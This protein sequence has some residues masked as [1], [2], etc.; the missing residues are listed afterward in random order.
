VDWLVTTFAGRKTL[1]GDDFFLMQ[2]AVDEGQLTRHAVLAR[3]QEMNQD[4][5]KYLSPIPGISRNYY[6][7]MGAMFRVLSALADRQDTEFVAP[8]LTDPE[9]HIRHYAGQAYPYI[10]SGVAWRPTIGY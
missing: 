10:E 2:L 9:Q 6:P 4:R 8:Y 1:T 5:P 7:G 3:L